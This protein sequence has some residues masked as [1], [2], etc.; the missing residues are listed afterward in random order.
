[1]SS[2][3]SRGLPGSHVLRSR[4]VRSRGV[5]LLRG[6]GRCELRDITANLPGAVLRARDLPS[7]CGTLQLWAAVDGFRLLYRFADCP[8]TI[9]PVKSLCFLFGLWRKVVSIAVLVLLWRIRQRWAR[10]AVRL[11]A[12]FLVN[13]PMG[14]ATTGFAL[15]R[16]KMAFSLQQ[17]CWLPDGEN[18]RP[19]RV[20]VA[21]SLDWS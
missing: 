12:S 6:L 5:P 9:K 1:M 16:I 13:I 18:G 17:G 21:P 8:F 11:H 4:R 15:T 7:G 19:A 14:L 3:L 10:G 20:Q 2:L